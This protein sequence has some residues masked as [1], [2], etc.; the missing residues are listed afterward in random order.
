MK[1]LK[2]SILQKPLPIFPWVGGKRKLAQKI[3]EIIKTQTSENFPK[4]IEP[5]CGGL[6]FTLEFNYQYPKTKIVCSDSNRWLIDTYKSISTNCSKVYNFLEELDSQ[7][8]ALPDKPSRKLWYYQLRKD[9]TSG[10]FKKFEESAVFIALVKTG[11]NGLMQ[12]NAKGELTTAFGFG[13]VDKLLNKDNFKLFSKTIC[14]WKFKYQQFEKSIQDV[15]KDS[16]VYLD[17][18]YKTSNQMY[19][20]SRINP[21]NTFDQLRLVNY[22]K[23]CIDKGAKIVAMSNSYDPEYWSSVFRNK[24]F[25]LYDIERNQG[26]HRNVVEKGRYKVRENLIV[27]Q[28]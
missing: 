16:L 23:S 18:I 28:G 5:F 12:I 19:S 27:L 2:K 25:K 7:W 6:G 10:K 24:N 17:P 1:N 22:M 14:K 3:I 15:T 4:L 8:K 9:F 20:G 21:E 11:Y 13:A 26:A